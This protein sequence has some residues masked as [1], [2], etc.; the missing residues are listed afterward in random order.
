MPILIRQEQQLVFFILVS[1]GQN[2]LLS[3]NHLGAKLISQYQSVVS[4]TYSNKTSVRSE[5]SDSATLSIS[6][7]SFDQN[8]AVKFSR[9]GTKSSY[10]D[11]S[12]WDKVNFPVPLFIKFS[13]NQKIPKQIKKKKYRWLSSLSCLITN[14]L[15]C[16]ISTKSTAIIMFIIVRLITRVSCRKGPTCHA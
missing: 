14:I 6:A 11:Q 7:V 4:R 15:W 3:I 5:L 10:Q 9:F 2:S 16:H 13:I 8:S 1:L 12:V